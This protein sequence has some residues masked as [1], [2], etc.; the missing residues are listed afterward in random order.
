MLESDGQ[1]VKT[2]GSSLILSQLRSRGCSQGQ[3]L[4]HGEQSMFVSLYFAFP[5]TCVGLRSL[6]DYNGFLLRLMAKKAFLPAPYQHSFAGKKP[7][8]KAHRS[9]RC[10][11]TGED[12]KATG[13]F[14]SLNLV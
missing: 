1:G 7:L 8:M 6:Y 5:L 11:A 10:R 4:C 2:G 3:N 14:L 13:L 12:K 9:K